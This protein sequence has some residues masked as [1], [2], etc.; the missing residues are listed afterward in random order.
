MDAVPIIYAFDHVSWLVCLIK[1]QCFTISMSLIISAGWSARQG[2]CSDS[3]VIEDSDLLGMDDVDACLT[4][5]NLLD[6]CVAVEFQTD[7]LTATLNC[8]FRSAV[9]DDLDIYTNDI[10]TY[11]FE[12]SGNPV[13]H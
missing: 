9:C 12:K 3:N 7:H 6:G 8:Y 10:W 13:S 5:C 4:E 11:Q 1:D 2:N